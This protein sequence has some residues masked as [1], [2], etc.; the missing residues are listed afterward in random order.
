MPTD[1]SGCGSK[2]TPE[3]GN[4]STL[5]RPEPELCDNDD[6]SEEEEGRRGTTDLQTSEEEIG[7]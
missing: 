3:R 5:V 7:F 4:P 1:G 2:G 6:K